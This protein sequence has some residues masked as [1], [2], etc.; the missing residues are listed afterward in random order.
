MGPDPLHLLEG[1]GT[2]SRAFRHGARTALAKCILISHN[3]TGR[4]TQECPPAVLAF[5]PLSVVLAKGGAPAVL[6][7][8]P[9]SPMRAFRRPCPLFP[10]LELHRLPS[11]SPGLS[12]AASPSLRHFQIR[13]GSVCPLRTGTGHGRPR[14][15]PGRCGCV[16][17]SLLQRG[18]GGA[19]C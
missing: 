9:L 8:A 18:C 1:N 13:S 2:P 10:P 4:P 3:H 19:V 5:A 7:P 16:V 12:L 11:P 17:T 14:R 15:A 6:A